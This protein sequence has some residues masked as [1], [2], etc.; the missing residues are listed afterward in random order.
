VN[1]SGAGPRKRAAHYAALAALC[2]RNLLPQSAK[3]AVSLF[4]VGLLQAEF[5]GSIGNRPR[6]VLNRLF[7]FH[8]VEDNGTRWLR[9]L[10]SS[11]KLNGGRAG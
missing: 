2:D 4:Q 5:I 11:I 7:T 1:R 9:K 3:F 6:P 10:L 8:P